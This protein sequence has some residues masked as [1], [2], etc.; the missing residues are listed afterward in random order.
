M[1]DRV[2]FWEGRAVPRLALT[3]L[4]LIWLSGCS[5]DVTRFD[6]SSSPF[7]NPFSSQTAQATPSGAAPSGKVAAAPLAPAT[8]VAS[9]PL[10]GAASPAPVASAT[11]RA[12]GSAAGW[13]AAGGTPVVVGQ[14]ESLDT[15][16]RRYGVPAQALLAANGLSSP[17]EVKGGM[18][19]VVPVYNAGGRAVASAPAAKTVADAAGKPAK[20]RAEEVAAN[21]TEPKAKKAK[22]D[23]KS[24]DKVAEKKK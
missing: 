13:S 20:K 1:S 4:A 7:T 19:I 15:L 22:A 23:A 17:A 5:A 3:G 18:R 14:G 12:G 8:T 24:E 6:A 21:D 9:A 10:P 16:S 2:A 11:Q